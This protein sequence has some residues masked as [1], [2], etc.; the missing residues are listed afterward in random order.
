MR[1]STSQLLLTTYGM[2]LRAGDGVSLGVGSAVGEGVAVGVLSGVGDG[3][4]SGVSP[5][6]GVGEGRGS[7][8]L[9][10]ARHESNVR[11]QSA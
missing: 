2:R 3:V 4:A 5:G 8:S 9:H 1:P 6:D 11:L 7:T 10:P